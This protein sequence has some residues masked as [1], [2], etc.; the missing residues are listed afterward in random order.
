MK[1]KRV[2]KKQ[3]KLNN[4]LLS[5]YFMSLFSVLLSFIMLL[6]TTYAWFYTDNTSTGN[7]IHSGELKVDMIH[8]TS[9]ENVSLRVN[10]KHAVFSSDKK[11]TPNRTQVEVVEVKNAGNVVLNYKLDFAPVPGDV[12]SAARTLE[13]ASLASLFTVYVKNG[14][15]TDEE[16]AQVEA[17][18]PT[19]SNGWEPIG[20]L[21]EVMSIS[22]NA[23][24]AAGTGLQ[25][26]DSAWFSIALQMGEPTTSEAV[27]NKSVPVYL[28]LEATQTLNIDNNSNSS[29]P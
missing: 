25:E 21:E 3:R 18:G 8:W 15:V 28:K 10:K 26:G 7:E 22:G 19:G 16:R 4:T 14:A 11:W 29:A 20:T 12:G 2:L 17:T 9:P 6:G 5:T 24:L 13:N 1:G 23:H 27:M